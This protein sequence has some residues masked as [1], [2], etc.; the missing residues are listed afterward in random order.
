MH[1]IIPVVNKDND[2]FVLENYNQLKQWLTQGC[3]EYLDKEYSSLSEAEDD[4]ELLEGIKDSLK[5]TLEEIKEPYADVEKKLEDLIKIIQEPIS[6]INRYKKEIT[7]REKADQIM[8]YAGTFDNELGN[9]KEK[10]LSSA[11]FLE[12]DWLTTKY[13]EKKWREA[14]YEKISGIVRDLNT[15]N[16]IGGKD[17][18]A[19]LARYYETLSLDNAREYLS[20]LN[21]DGSKENISTLKDNDAV[22]G[23]KI[24]K[25]YGTNAQMSQVLDELDLLDL[26]YEELEDGMPKEFEEILS[27]DMD[28]FVAFDIETSGTEGG[29]DALPSDITEIGAVKVINGKIVET[30]SELCNPGRP[31]LPRIQR[32]TGITNEMIADKPSVNET[33]R[34]F[35]DFCGDLPLIGHNIKSMDLHYIAD[36]AKRNGI[37]FS[38][39]FFDT[40][41]YAKKFKEDNNWNNLKLEY[42]AGQFGIKDESHHRAYN[43]AE[44]NVAVY[45]KLKDL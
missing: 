12:S 39:K 3:Q 7:Y 28:S 1:E 29:P 8:E 32:L 19:L 22:V 24:L 21:D 43:D 6:R 38:N 11:N 42:L 27:P 2:V 45:Y 44:V 5:N 20:N 37:E 34:K 17:I 14:V 10:I 13:T 15:I 36:A 16:N 30:F 35:K 26:E 31:I 23:Y 33:I 41:L 18:K 25:I 40:Y 4:K 9:Y